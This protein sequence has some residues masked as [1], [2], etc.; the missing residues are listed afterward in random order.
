MNSFSQK[1]SIRAYLSHA[2]FYSPENGPYIETYLSI[3]GKSIHFVRNENGKFQGTAMVTMLFK[4]NDSIKAFKKYDLHTIEIPDTAKIN[5]IVFDQQRIAI[6]NGNYELELIIADKNRELPPFKAKDN[7]EIHFDKRKVSISDIELVESYSKASETSLMGK[8]GYDFIP[9][10]DMFF[11]QSIKKLSF[12]AEVYSTIEALG[13]DAP[14]VITSS[15]QSFETGKPV[16][17]YFRIK[18]ETSNHVNVVFSDFNISELPSGNYNLSI[19]VRDKENK[20]IASQI[21]FF[22]RSNPGIQFNTA[23]L[24]SIIT[25][26]SFVSRYTNSDSL[27]EYILMCTPVASA[28]E[29][30]FISYNNRTDLVTLQQFLLNFWTQRNPADPGGEWNKYYN[31]VLAVNQEFGYTN[32]MGYETDRGRVYLQY[33]PPNERTK[34]TMNPDSYPYEIWHYYQ[35]ANQSNMRFVFYTR[36]QS[37]N[38]Y[39]ILHSTVLGEIKNVT[40]QYDLKRSAHDLRPKDTD[41]ELYKSPYEEEMFG[42]HSGEYFNIRK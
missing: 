28:N 23:S 22:Q 7:L 18:R 14:F 10:Q 40:W 12:Y 26:N 42:E 20:E 13:A 3:L 37:L 16:E 27:H 41:N 5:F 34:E 21:L 11:P 39:N 32:K 35:I 38:D 6:P 2:S 1:G 30:L 33:G 36:D 17:N 19:S 8:S 15:I 4:Q 25:S 31:T 29:K 24:Q 9:Y